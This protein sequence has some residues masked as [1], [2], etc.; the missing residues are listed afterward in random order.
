MKLAYI[1]LL[2]LCSTAFASDALPIKGYDK[3][4]ISKHEPIPLDVAKANGWTIQTVPAVQTA[5]GN[6]D[7]SLMSDIPPQLLCPQQ[8]TP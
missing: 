7:I 2:P 5:N 4:C 1:L 3:P 6:I 8:A